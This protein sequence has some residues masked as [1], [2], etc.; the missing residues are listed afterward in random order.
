M[1]FSAEGSFISAAI[2]TGTG[3]A[4]YRMTKDTNYQLFSLSPVFFGIQQATEGFLWVGIGNWS[5]EVIAVWAKIFLFFAFCFWPAW[6]PGNLLKIEKSEKNRKILQPIFITGVLF[7]LVSLISLFIVRN[8]ASI[9]HSSI[10]YHFT[11]Y[12]PVG[13]WIWLT[14][15]SFYIFCCVVP[16]YF[17]ELFSGTRYVLVTWVSIVVAYLFKTETF[18]SVWCFFAAL[19]SFYLFWIIRRQVCFLQKKQNDY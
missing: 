18:I 19:I 13:I 12:S 6:I 5:D 3:I 8:M 9:N 15:I 7:S 11:D 14:V 1:C 4:G 17:S 2:L 16:L 10:S